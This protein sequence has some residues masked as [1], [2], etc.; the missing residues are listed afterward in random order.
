MPMQFHYC[1]DCGTDRIVESA[2][3]FDKK[4]KIFNQNLFV[5]VFSLQ[6]TQSPSGKKKRR[7]SAYADHMDQKEAKEGRQKFRTPTY[8]YICKVLE[9]FTFE[10]VKKKLL[11]KKP[12]EKKTL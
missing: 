1:T 12:F 2:W 6:L 5:F 7:R 9:A 11:K 8:A 3:F 4:L 10:K